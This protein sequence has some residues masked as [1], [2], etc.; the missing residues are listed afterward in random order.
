MRFSTNSEACPTRQPATL[1][2]RL[3]IGYGRSRCMKRITLLLLAALSIGTAQAPRKVT[4]AEVMKAHR[5]L[6]LI[7][8]HNDV[9]S[10]TLKGFDIGQP[11]ATGH[12]DI[13]R[14]REGG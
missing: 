5:S 4:D 14:L 12:T 11:A 9:T 8:T 7:D 6:L 3:V 2:S 1:G 13:P 10:K